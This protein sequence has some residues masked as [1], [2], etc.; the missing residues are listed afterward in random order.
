[1]KEP[2]KKSKVVEEKPPVKKQTPD[3]KTK[4][5]ALKNSYLRY[6]E[7]VPIQRLAA[8]WIGKDEDTILRWKKEDHIFAE[9]IAKK[10]ALFVK[11]N[12]MKVKNPEFLLERLV[13]EDFGD[14]EKAKENKT[15][16]NF[17]TR[18]SKLIP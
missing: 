16:D 14:K 12:V 10:K 8:H 9:S 18:I 17:M 15:L 13:N 4:V 5:I 6:F 7:V 3:H 2:T 1:M 11:S